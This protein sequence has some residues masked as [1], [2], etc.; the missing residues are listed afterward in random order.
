MNRRSVRTLNRN[1]RAP[2]MAPLADLEAEATENIH[3]STEEPDWMTPQKRTL[4]Y[5]GRRCQKTACGRTD[6][7]PPTT[8]MD[9]TDVMHLVDCEDCL[10]AMARKGVR[11]TLRPAPVSD[12]SSM[13][14]TMPRR[15]SR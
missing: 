8:S 3:S 5:F 4:H 1:L 12:D 9:T 11:K 7:G 2:G 13:D 15:V 14:V 6:L 10:A